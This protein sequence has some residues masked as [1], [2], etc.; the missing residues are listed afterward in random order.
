[1]VAT[2]QGKNICFICHGNVRKFDNLSGK[3]YILKI[4]RGNW[5]LSGKLTAYDSLMLDKK[6][7]SNHK[8]VEYV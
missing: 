7:C 4:V 8:N 6:R 1:M 5:E 3:I 2:C